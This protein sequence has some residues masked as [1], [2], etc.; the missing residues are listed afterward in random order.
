MSDKN[1]K[2]QEDAKWT[3]VEAASLEVDSITQ[4]QLALSLDSLKDSFDSKIDE[5]SKQMQS[6]TDKLDTKLKALTNHFSQVNDK[7]MKVSQDLVLVKSELEKLNKMKRLE[8]ALSMTDSQSFEY[9]EIP[10]MDRETSST[11]VK[12]ILQYFFQGYGYRVS[13]SYRINLSDT[14]GSKFRQNLMNQ[15]EHL[16]GH[17]PRLVEDDDGTWTIFEF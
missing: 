6:A 16:I 4:K 11:L 12:S 15:V 10:Y 8:L 13:K 1:L 9:I 17:K 3:V 5:V 14:D 2:I 7:V